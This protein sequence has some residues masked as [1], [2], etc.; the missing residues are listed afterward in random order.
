[1]PIFSLRHNQLHYW[2]SSGGGFKCCARFVLVEKQTLF[3]AY[4]CWFVCLPSC[5]SCLCVCSGLIALTVILQQLWVESQTYY[6]SEIN[7]RRV[8]SEYWPGS[9]M[10][11][12]AFIKHNYWYLIPSWIQSAGLDFIKSS[13]PWKG[14]ALC[15][16]SHR[17]THTL[18][19]F[20]PLIYALTTQTHSHRQ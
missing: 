8:A 20:Y 14:I 7:I 16:S 10:L 3:W 9:V 1:M 12:F 2:M 11:G 13:V 15:M 4:V 5:L 19:P 6:N 17:H 18:T